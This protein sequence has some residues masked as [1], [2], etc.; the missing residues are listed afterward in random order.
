MCSRLLQHQ[1]WKRSGIILVE[2]KK[3]KRKKI[4]EASKKERKKKRKVKY[5]KRWSRR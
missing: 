1:A 3:M 4:D 2:W 5:T